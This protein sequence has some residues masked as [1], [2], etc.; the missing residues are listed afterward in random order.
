M[1]G[2]KG[3]R[4]LR[5]Q[6]PTFGP[7]DFLSGSGEMAVRIRETDWS[8]HPF[9]PPAEWPHSIRS[10]LSICLNSA[11]P[12]AIYWGS[13]LRLLYNDAWA[14]IPGPR[15]PAA[16]GAPAREVWS[17]IWSIIEPQ[18]SEVIRTGTGLFLED[19]LLP[20]RRFG[21]EEETYWNYSFTPIRGEEG[22]IIGIFNSGS[23]TT[24][25]VVQRRHAE[26]LVKLNEGL[27]TCRTAQEGLE[28]ALALLGNH[29]G[30]TR[31]G[32]RERGVSGGRTS[33]TV[34]RAWSAPEAVDPEDRPQPGDAAEA[35]MTEG[36]VLRVTK[37]DPA[38]DAA[39]RRY[40]ERWGAFSAVEV[41]WTERGRLTAGLF[42]HTRQPRQFSALD[43]SAI[44][45]V[46][47]ATMSWVER[48]RNREREAIMGR[49]IDHRAR[50]MLAVV[51]SITRLTEAGTLADYRA[52][53]GDR[54]VALS[55]VHSLLSRKRWTE[56]TF[57]D[58]VEQ[59]FEPYGD[60]LS[61]RISLD[62][63]KVSVSA[64]EAQLLTMILHELTTNAVKHGSLGSDNGTLSLEWTI[65]ADGA[66]LFRWTEDGA[67][68]S[69]AL[70]GELRRGFGTTLIDRVV[71]RHFGGR[72]SRDPRSRGMRYEIVFPRGVATGSMP[73]D[74]DDGAG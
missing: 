41:P 22:D 51:L 48:E 14:P 21:F 65:E 71:E 54:I 55:R 72:L 13:E 37:S 20:M 1:S 38:L 23:E 53:L 36:R 47:E 32:L 3:R 74:R 68:S 69:P 50:N 67:A 44:E 2:R 29:F 5:Q 73:I 58:L 17:D 39:G 64:A 12:T 15:H 45:K 11:F 33:F 26:F 24:E 57:R 31:T 4:M 35:T 60:T 28:F 70:A 59:E 49:E 10:A 52:K 18:F 30:A 7:M 46:L 56:A 62:G 16:L 27:R 63:P 25:N 66:L 61:E 43:I 9:G 19:Q 40:L 8:D 34:T 6:S 42:V